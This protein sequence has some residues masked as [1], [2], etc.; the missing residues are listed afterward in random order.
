MKKHRGLKRYYKNLA[1]KVDD[2]WNE[3]FVDPSTARFYLWHIHFDR[4]G[5]GTDSFKRRKP[6]LD[7]LVRHFELLEEKTKSL[8]TEFQLWATLLDFSSE[9]D[10]LFLHTANSTKDAYPW[11]IGKLSKQANLKNKELLD[12]INQLS[13]F[14]VLYGEAD[15]NFCVIY[16]ENVG[17]GIH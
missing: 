10:A 1:I 13:G 8:N 14:T 2:W 11:E 4:Y 15:Q 12:Y 6:H 5:Y 16:K 3:E 9:S 17:M 7:K